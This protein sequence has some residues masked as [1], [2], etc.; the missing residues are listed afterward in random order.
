MVNKNWILDEADKLGLELGT[1]AS[2][3]FTVIQALDID[4]VVADL[5]EKTLGQTIKHCRHYAILLNDKSDEI[6]QTFVA[7]HEIGHVRLHPGISTAKFRKENLTGLI[8][9]VEAEANT[10]AIEMMKR[11]IDIDTI[12]LTNKFQVIEYL[13]LPHT[14]DHLVI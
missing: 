8:Q 6:V 10:F 12:D 14:L 1:V 11:T 7:W 5:G 2:N 13:G 3:P 9:G 4:L